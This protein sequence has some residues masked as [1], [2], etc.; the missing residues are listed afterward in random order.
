[1]LL[2][3]PQDDVLVPC[4]CV[5][6]CMAQCLCR[7]CVRYVLA[8]TLSGALLAPS[9]VVRV[10]GCGAPVLLGYQ[11]NNCDVALFKAQLALYSFGFMT[12]FMTACL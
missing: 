1:M 5:A 7:P 4:Y 8:T 12:G 11:D 10:R 9:L 2:N 6:A 3:V